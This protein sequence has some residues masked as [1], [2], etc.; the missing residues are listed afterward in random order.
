[1]SP[2]SQ[3]TLLVLGLVSV[4]ISHFVHLK[5]KDTVKNPIKLFTFFTPFPYLNYKIL[6][7]ENKQGLINPYA[8]FGPVYF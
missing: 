8:L 2:D 3:A 6:T 5:I 4:Q 7:I 1:M